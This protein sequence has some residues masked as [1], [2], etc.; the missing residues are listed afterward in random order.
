MRASGMTLSMETEAPAQTI[1]RLQREVDHVSE[2]A[3]VSHAMA[4]NWRQRYEDCEKA[5]ASLERKVGRLQ[6]QLQGKADPGPRRASD[7]ADA[8]EAWLIEEDAEV[9]A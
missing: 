2:Q 9:E 4:M 6:R 3:R 1:A 7:P 8:M 5:R